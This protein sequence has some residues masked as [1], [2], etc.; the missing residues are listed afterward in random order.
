MLLFFSLFILRI[1]WVSTWLQG[2]R[3]LNKIEM[4]LPFIFFICAQSLQSCLTLQPH[5]LQAHGL[6]CPWDSPGKNT[7]VGCHAL[8]QGI[9]MTQGSNLHLLCLLHWQAGSLPLLPHGEFLLHVTYNQ[10]CFQFS[11]S[12]C[13]PLFMPWGKHWFVFVVVVQLL[14]HVQLFVPPLSF[15]ISWSLLRL[16]C[17]VLTI[18]SWLAYM[19]LSTDLQ[20]SFL[21]NRKSGMTTTWA[22]SV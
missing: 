12:A 21:E 2:D 14:S 7:G 8:F 1:L 4:V 13:F 11:S 20:E 19:F 15:T 22:S 17:L 6:F 3:A 10:F 9:F 18:A 16:L 5:G